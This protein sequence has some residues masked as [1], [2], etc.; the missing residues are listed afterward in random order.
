MLA[1]KPS[2]GKTKKEKLAEEIAKAI[3]AGRPMAVETVDFSDPNRA[4]TCLEVDFPIVPLNEI[5][6]IE[7]KGSGALK[8]VYQV[9]KWWA[10]RRSTVFRALL[11]AAARAAPADPA[12]AAR[13]VWDGYYG[14]YQV[15]GDLSRLRVG[16]IFM[17][18][19]TTVVEAA[20]L[21]MDVYGCDLNP[22]AWLVVKNELAD[23]DPSAVE[24]L[25]QAIES[26][27][28]P[29]LIPFYTCVC[30]RGHRGKWIAVS[31][32]ELM[33]D[34]FD[35][36][37]LKP[38]E[39]G[40]FVYQGP[41]I[42]YVFWAKHGHCQVKG[43]GHRTPIV[44]S[45]V[46]A[47]KTIT[48]KY[49]PDVRCPRCESVFDVESAEARLAQGAAFIVAETERPF[50][51][52]GPDAS[53][54]CPTCGHNDRYPNLSTTGGD[55]RIELT[56]L[57]HPRWFAG[58]PGLEPDGSIYGGSADDDL[59]STLD[60]F[61]SRSAHCDIVEVRGQLPDVVRCPITGDLFRPSEGTIGKRS[62]FICGACGTEQTVLE[63]TKQQHSTA[64]V[65]AYAFQGYCPECDRVGTPNSGRF[66]AAMKNVH[67]IAAA[68][69]EWRER[70]DT[71][72]SGF[73][74][75][76]EI[77]F[78]H[79]THQRR[80]LP[81]HGYTH[82]WK[83]FNA[84]QLLVH[85]QI[86]RAIER[87]GEH[88]WEVRE[89]VLGAFQQ[90]LRNQNMFAFWNMQRALEPH[91]SNNNYHPKTMVV[92]NCVFS[93]LGRGS[94]TACTEAI[95]ESLEWRR[96]PWDI[97]STGQIEKA[98]PAYRKHAA[99][100]E[101]VLIGDSPIPNAVV[102]CRSATDLSS[103]PSGSFDLIITDPPFGDN[104][105]YSELA[106]FF[107]V[108]LRLVLKKHY[109]EF[110]PQYCPKTLEAVANRARHP[111]D[112]DNFYK[113]ILTDCWKEA[114]RLLKPA[115][116]LAF[117]FHHS[118]DEPWVAV[119][120]S[121]FEAG[122]F[123]EATYP[124]RSDETKGEGQFGSQKIE[125]DIIHVC[126]KRDRAPQTVSWARMRREA[127]REVRL[128]SELL[129]LHQKEGLPAGDVK[130]IKR[131]KALE[132]F[133]RHYGKVYVDEGKEFT[134][135]DAL[136]G[137]NQLLDEESGGGKEPPPTNAEPMTRQFLRL[138]DGVTQ[139][140]RD[141]MQKL[142]R[143]T[144]IDPAEYEARG[145]CK[146]TQKV[147]HLVSAEEIAKDWFGK[148]RRK[149]TADYDQSMVLIGASFPQSGINVMDTLNNDNF[150]PHPALGRL[151]KWHINHGATSPVRNAATIASQIYSTWDAQNQDK[152]SQMKLFFDDGEEG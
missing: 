89:I 59:E 82:F 100:S 68:E 7:G 109:P 141:Q 25:F 2:K 57:I 63:S 72:L 42:A 121:L 123:I 137:I 1:T 95:I 58:G 18:G 71:D 17:G 45:P 67:Q 14:N 88:P 150:R 34:S 97:V 60:W 133:S 4:K 22:L 47:A 151:L 52:I 108:W 21:G 128:V 84:R 62:S 98:L 140:P 142:L 134:V 103:L 102:E 20:R 106:D 119:L 113:R 87:T 114:I 41:E 146:E 35:P 139:Q 26:E 49:W 53:V 77:P 55:K 107:Y 66:F 124:I 115:G 143:G 116:M 96:N 5:A 91:F 90:Y 85:S 40:R 31:T 27:V 144:T 10:R 78:G 38:E 44:G 122:F 9:M 147:Y 48:V 118:E 37:L 65:A 74:P 99:S 69:R 56:V 130:V 43:C 8:P 39:R 70:K 23:L 129:E 36:V 127:L 92:E 12:K 80:P 11:L 28:K 79:E 50:T 117:T 75:T 29:Q 33:A 32:G 126:R 101:K 112:P 83:M 105:Q 24:S 86:L 104:I 3:G 46:I 120:E 51:L 93:H 111:D 94:W 30:P 64:P 132:Y 145:W 6:A 149:L 73:W 61:E 125:Y 135:R 131:G 15:H 152:T 54:Q 81:E 136:I 19:G 148:H 13:A 76:S 138:F 16:D 110:Q